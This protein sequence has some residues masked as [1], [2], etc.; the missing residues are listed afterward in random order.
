MW[1]VAIVDVVGQS[2]RGCRGHC[3]GV[4]VS[5]R[6]GH[7][8]VV[9]LWLLLLLALSLLSRLGLAVGFHPRGIHQVV[10][11]D[12]SRGMVVVVE[13]DVGRNV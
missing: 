10:D 5:C 3:R 11:N 9:V 13:K 6:G 2:C 4:V 1:E 8:G 7:G 12:D